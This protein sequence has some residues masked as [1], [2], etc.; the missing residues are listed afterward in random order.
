MKFSK[1]LRTYNLQPIR[2]FTLLEVLLV[3]AL[4]AI[5][6]GIIIVAINPAKQL[7]SARN[8]E[9]MSDI[10]QIDSAINQYYIDNFE[11][12]ATLPSSLTEICNTGSGSSVLVDVNDNNCLDNSLINLSALVPDYIVA[13]PVD[14]QGGSILAFLNKIIPTAY[15]ADTDGTGYSIMKNA[16]NRITTQADNAELNQTI[17][18]GPDATGGGNLTV[19]DATVVGAEETTDGN[20][21]I[22]TFTGDGTF[23]VNAGSCIVEVL[24]V[25]GGGAGGAYS[26]GGGGAGGLKYNTVYSIDSGSYDV[27][28]GNGGIGVGRNSV[29][30]P[31]NGG[32]SSFDTLIT[33][34]GGHGSTGGDSIVY[35]STVGGSGGGGGSTYSGLEIGSAGTSGQGKAGGNGAEGGVYGSGGGGGAGTVGGSATSSERGNGG[36]GLEI[37]ITGT[38]VYYAGGGGGGSYAESPG[39]NGGLGGGG[40][41]GDGVSNLGDNGVDGLGGGGGGSGSSDSG[42]NGGSGIVI[43]KYLKTP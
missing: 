38:P 14:P 22:Q 41:G 16:N 32:S 26:A 8:T 10:R 36:N 15:A 20:Y 6:A 11:F 40:N 7:A 29:T 39:G 30:E 5:L 25:A 35:G 34:G 4:I 13:I 18:I 24:V 1:K 33:V 37:S 42:T 3:I 2:G 9:R 19:C 12:P 31:D 21:T 27:V 43:I 23:T 17:A 28:V